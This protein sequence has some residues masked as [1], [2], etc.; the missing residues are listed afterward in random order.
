MTQTGDVPA[1]PAPV[2]RS[3]R[4][5]D[6]GTRAQFAVSAHVNGTRAARPRGGVYSFSFCIHSF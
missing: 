1:D 6:G 5:E 4:N 2:E 3:L